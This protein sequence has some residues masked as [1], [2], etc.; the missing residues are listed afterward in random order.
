MEVNR[1]SHTAIIER[2]IFDKVQVEL[3]KKQDELSIP[4][5][6]EFKDIFKEKL[7]CG[8]CGRK[9]KRQNWVSKSKLK[10][11]YYTCPGYQS[12]K[13]TACNTKSISIQEL[14]QAIINKLQNDIAIAIENKKNGEHYENSLAYK[15]RHLTQ[16]NKLNALT[17]ILKALQEQRQQNDNS[18]AHGSI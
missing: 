1:K 13:G 2:D 14:K 5:R 12:S 11:I 17:K 15:L 3:L 4:E 9:I 10:T 18:L 16:Q 7:F 6:G 8:E